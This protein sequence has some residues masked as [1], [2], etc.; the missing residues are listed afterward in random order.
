M[1]RIG[2]LLEFRYI[3]HHRQN[4]FLAMS[5]LKDISGHLSTLGEPS[6]YQDA[7]SATMRLD[8]LFQ[9]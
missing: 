6:C 9:S 3:R 4:T 8:A 5:T 2:R 7:V 1:N